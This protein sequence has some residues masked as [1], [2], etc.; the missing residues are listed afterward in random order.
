MNISKKLYL[1]FAVVIIIS[2]I[3]GI[4]SIV[5][6]QSLYQNGLSMYE[7]QVVGVEKLS[8]AVKN[9]TRAEMDVNNTVLKSL[10]DDQKGALDNQKEFEENA[11]VF[12]KMLSESITV[13]E[14]NILYQPIIMRFKNDYLPNSRRIMALSIADIPDH[15]RKL[16]INVL[17]AANIE[18]TGHLNA[19]LDNMTMAHLSL[20]EYLSHNNSRFKNILIGLQFSFLAAAIIASIILS[21]RIV[22]S[23]VGVVENIHEEAQQVHNGAKQISSNSTEL[24]DVA[25]Q[26]H[27]VVETLVSNMTAINEQTEKNNAN[28]KLANDLSRK[29]KEHAIKGNEKIEDMI[30]SIDGIKVSSDSISNV[31]KVIENIASQTN[32]LALNASVESARAGDAGKSFNI[33]AEEVRNLAIQSHNA[34]QETADLIKES[35]LRVD[36]GTKIARSTVEAFN[37]IVSDITEMSEF[38][39]EIDN[40]SMTQTNLISSVNNSIEQISKSVDTN[41]AASQEAAAAAQEMLAQADA[42]NNTVSVLEVKAAS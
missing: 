26:Q 25:V 9:F 20:G 12:E 14:L 8:E 16:E 40:S 41:K 23:I 18:I 38:I 36:E 31:I 33:V 15:I 1:S 28:A 39:N 3:V 7:E 24:S 30:K 27:G 13:D 17:L 2:I 4:M 5:G 22:K 37:T 21:R 6:M 19:A 29:S 42:L 34:A 32:I 10:Y 11:A 35:I